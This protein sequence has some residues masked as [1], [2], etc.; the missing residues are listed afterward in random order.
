MGDAAAVRNAVDAAVRAAHSA[1]PGLIVAEGGFDPARVARAIH[2]VASAGRARPFLAIDCGRGTPDSI[3]RALFGTTHARRDAAVEAIEHDSLLARAAGGTLVVGNLC[4]LPASVQLRLSR[5]LRDG[6]LTLG[7]TVMPLGTRLLA[8]A[9]P[10]LDADVREHRFRPEL[11]DRLQRIRIDVPP[12]RE[13][14]GDMP[15]LIAALFEEACRAAGRQM[16]LAPAA[17]TALA[18]LSWPGNLAELERVLEQL[19]R[20]V[21]GDVIRQE[22]VLEQV[23]KEIAGRMMADR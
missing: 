12:L 16:S 4:E 7:E 5:L 8:T 17:T 20:T 14:R 22:D 13:R 11:F 21:S 10:R 1:E 19:V 18:A 9:L 3:A 2:D 15:V 6:E 23:V